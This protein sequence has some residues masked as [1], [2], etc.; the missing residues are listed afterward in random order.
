MLFFVILVENHIFVK[1]K[2]IQREIAAH[3]ALT[4]L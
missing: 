1:K 2:Q 4:F 3:I